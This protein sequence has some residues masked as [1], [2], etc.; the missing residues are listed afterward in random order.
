M[1][2]RICTD[3]GCWCQSSDQPHVIPLL[4]AQEITDFVNSAPDAPK[5][6]CQEANDIVTSREKTYGTMGPSFQEGGK[7]LAL[8]SSAEDS[9]GEQLALA[10]IAAKLVRRKNSP[11]N[12]DHYVDL[13]GYMEVLWQARLSAI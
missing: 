7:V 13:A 9:P 12:R 6:V 4:Q 8:I 10:I 2:D 3:R 1:A 11:D 5:T